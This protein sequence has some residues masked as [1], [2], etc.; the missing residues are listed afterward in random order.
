M[1]LRHAGSNRPDAAPTG[2]PQ[3]VGTSPVSGPGVTLSCFVRGQHYP[4]SSYGKKAR[5]WGKL[6]YVCNNCKRP[7]EL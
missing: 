6:H 1:S 7:G 5:R 3:F 4:K 2:N